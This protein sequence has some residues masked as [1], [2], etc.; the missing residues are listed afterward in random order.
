MI[1]PGIEFLLMQKLDLQPTVNRLGINFMGCF[2]AFKA[3]A[4]APLLR[5]E[6]AEHRV[7]VLCTELCSL[8]M[9]SSQD[10]DSIIANSLFADGAAAA[11]VGS[12]PQ[13][14]EPSLWEIIKTNSIGL[15]NSLDKMSWEAS[16]HGYLMG[17]STYSSRSDP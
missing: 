1:A 6:N 8:H 12:H 15:E 14:N 3:L 5:P 16:D 17:L 4:A 10:H 13:K 2:G 7:L 11:I 9:Q